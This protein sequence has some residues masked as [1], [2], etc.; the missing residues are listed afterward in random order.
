LKSEKWIEV[1]GRPDALACRVGVL[2]PTEK[3][4]GRAPDLVLAV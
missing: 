1:S 3:G 4:V 2:V